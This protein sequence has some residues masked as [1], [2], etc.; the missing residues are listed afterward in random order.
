MGDFKNLTAVRIFCKNA[1]HDR[2]RVFSVAVIRFS[3]DEGH[4]FSERFVEFVY[5]RDELFGVSPVDTQI[6]KLS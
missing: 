1:F 4:T 6:F 3:T 5:T 2:V